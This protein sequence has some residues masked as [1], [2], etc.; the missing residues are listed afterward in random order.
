MYLNKLMM[1]SVKFPLITFIK[2]MTSI[3]LLLL[4][5]DLLVHTALQQFVT[6]HLPQVFLNHCYK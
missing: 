4:S 6:R 3:F 1:S 2:G 5:H